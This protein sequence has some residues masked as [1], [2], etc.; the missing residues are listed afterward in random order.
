MSGYI[1]NYKP[2]VTFNDGTRPAKPTA[3]DT[4]GKRKLETLA[5]VKFAACVFTG[6]RH[7]GVLFRGKVLEV[8]WKNV[9]EQSTVNAQYANFQAGEL[10][11]ST[12]LID[13]GWI[14]GIIVVPPDSN[15]SII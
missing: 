10:Y 14:E 15:V 9:S 1:V 6:A 13:F 5:N 12:D 7:T 2:T 4:N 8:H 11:E 3:L